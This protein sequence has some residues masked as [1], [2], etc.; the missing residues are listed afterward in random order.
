MRISKTEI[1]DRY[2]ACRQKLGKA[3]GSTI[4]CKTA[5][6]KLADIFYYWPRFTDLVKEAGEISPGWNSKIPNEELYEEYA[7][8]CLHLGKIPTILELRIATRQLKTRTHRVRNRY[9]TIAEFDQSFRKWL[10]KQSGDIRKILDFPGWDRKNRPSKPDEELQSIP[11]PSYSFHPYLPACLQYLNVLARGDVPQNENQ[12]QSAAIL[13]ERRCADAFQCLGFEIENFGQGKGRVSDFVALA[14]RERFAVIVD[15]KSRSEGYILGTEDR[16][17][18]EYA[19]KHGRELQS[20][21][22]EKI[23][24][25][26]VAASFREKDLDQLTVYLTDSPIRSADLITASALIR[27]VEDSIRER[28]SFNL[29]K[30]DELFFG[31]KIISK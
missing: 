17:F 29:S 23:Y 22:F 21:G 15:A 13:F 12:S 28:H 1:L 31:N 18:L 27:I 9:G 5:G 6:V 26:I 4:F 11:S 3:P 25:V 2:H 10:E 30:L 24:L 7:K 16:K 20:K 19:V 8:V 14:R